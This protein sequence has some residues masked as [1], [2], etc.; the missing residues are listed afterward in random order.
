MYVWRPDLAPKGL[1]RRGRDP[2]NQGVEMASY[3][4]NTEW[5][6]QA[7]L[8]FL[9]RHS[10]HAIFSAK[11]SA[12]RL[13][14]LQKGAAAIIK[15]AIEIAGRSE[16]NALFGQLFL[17][18]AWA[19]DLTTIES[20]EFRVD[21]VAALSSERTIPLILVTTVLAQ[22]R[23]RSH[24]AVPLAD[25]FRARELGAASNQ[26]L[27]ETQTHSTADDSGNLIYAGYPYDPYK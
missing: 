25:R 24:F 17:S 11:T 3:H 9:G 6:N 27:E 18:Q 12:G 26:C 20:S 7:L 5:Q 19:G 22:A 2:K 16:P 13:M 15:E 4:G 14:I 8:P 10:G 1:S 23:E 21:D